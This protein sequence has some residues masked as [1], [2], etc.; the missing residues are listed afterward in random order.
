MELIILPST[1]RAVSIVRRLRARQPSRILGDPR[2]LA[3]IDGGFSADV[4]SPLALWREIK[5]L[6][7]LPYR[8][9][10]FPDQIYGIGPS[11]RKIEVQGNT[12]AVSTIEAMI[13]WKFRPRVFTVPILASGR[14]IDALTELDCDFASAPLDSDAR[15]DEALRHLV[16]P[17]LDY[18]QGAD[19]ELLSQPNFRYKTNHAMHR[20]L[21]L[22]LGEIEGLVRLT[23]WR[24]DPET[25]TLL[26]DQ[27]KAA[28]RQLL[29]EMKK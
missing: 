27:L 14:D 16:G 6:P 2:L 15:L 8:L 28:R 1:K 4:R 24:D 17:V 12:Y 11:F 21:G 26:L 22:G 9:F 10:S 3:G 25:K 13:A 19:K 18:C 7:A 29:A 5:D 20:T 23:D